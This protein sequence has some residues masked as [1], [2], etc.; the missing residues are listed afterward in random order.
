[1]FDRLTSTFF[2]LAMNTLDTR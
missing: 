1:V 2:L